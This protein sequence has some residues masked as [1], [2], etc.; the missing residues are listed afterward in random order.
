MY[1]RWCGEGGSVVICDSCPKVFCI[2]CIKRNFGP[3][4]AHRILNLKDRWTCYICSPQPIDDLIIK[5]GWDRLWPAPQPSSFAADKF[6]VKTQAV[7]VPTGSRR[8]LICHDVSRGRERFAIPVYNEVDSAPAPLDFVYVN[9]HVSGGAR[10]TN[11]PNFLTCCSCTDQCADPSRCECALA[12]DGF[13]YDEERKLV[14]DKPGGVFECNARCSCHVDRCTNR[15]VGNGPTL[16]LEVF[17]CTDPRKGWGVRCNVDIPAGAYV[18]DYLGEVLRD[19]DAEMRGLVRC[20]EYLY[21]MDF[22]GR[23][24]AC[25]RLHELDMKDGLF[26]IP[27][28]LDVDVGQLSRD[29]QREL[30]G[31]EMFAKLDATGAVDR[32]AKRCLQLDASADEKQTPSKR[33][34]LF[35]THH[36][37]SSSGSGSGGFVTTN[38]KEPTAPRRHTWTD[39]SRF[40]RLREWQKARA[41]LTDRTLLENDD[42]MCVIDARWHGSVA[43]FFN[44]SCQPNLEVVTVFVESHNPA[45]PRYV[46]HLSYI[47]YICFSSY[48]AFNHVSTRFYI[49]IVRTEWPYS[50]ATVSRPAKSCATTTATS[51]ATSTA[52]IES[53]SAVSLAYYF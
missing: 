6:R 37:T 49:S 2:A 12:M 27:Y 46:Y 19:E 7:A 25:K 13:A 41:I 23:S 52:N 21:S 14:N 18:A 35:E 36:A 33:R 47:F 39:K 44:H 9:K 16:P 1:C 24:H 3:S 53:A 42:Q 32:A 50:P 11:N 34:S 22:L 15:L 5:N 4:E 31:D 8:H 40:R 20:D 38:P 26:A 48:Q 45:I 10:M 30:L 17:R 28:E 51:R 29:A 43:R